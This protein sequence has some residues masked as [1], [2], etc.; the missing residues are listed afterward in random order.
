MKKKSSQSLIIQRMIYFVIAM[1]Q[2]TGQSIFLQ[3]DFWFCISMDWG[4]LFLLS[5]SKDSSWWE[6]DT[7][8]Y[9][10]R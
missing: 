4:H 8:K 10:L 7:E 9:E 2:C 5:L 1:N 6:N 3:G